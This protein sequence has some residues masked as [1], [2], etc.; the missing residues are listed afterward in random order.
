LGITL[1]LATG[2]SE[3]IRAL[4]KALET[5]LAAGYLPEQQHGLPITALFQPHIKFFVARLDGEAVGCG[6]VALFS[7]FAEAKRMFVA[8]A[9]R[10]QGIAQA[11]LARLEAETRAAGLAWLRLETGNKQSAAMRLYEAAGFTRCG[12]FGD[13]LAMTPQAIETS[14]FY[15]RRVK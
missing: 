3:E 4:I 10:G 12:A 5:D 2:P 6:G 11:I 1:E 13:Y 7:G 14:V 15:E 9:A 8:P